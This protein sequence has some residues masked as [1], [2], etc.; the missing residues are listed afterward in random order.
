M[1]TNILKHT[2]L[3]FLFI[4]VVAFSYF[5][6]SEWYDIAMLNKTSDYPWGEIN[7]NPWY[8]KDP[9]SYA[10]VTLLFGISYSVTAI[11]IAYFGYKKY[12]KALI[13]TVIGF[14]LIFFSMMINAGIE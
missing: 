12:N 6:I 8:Y 9:N 3:T 14:L 10:K 2:A 4:I 13:Y 5:N 1:S 11:L 7:N